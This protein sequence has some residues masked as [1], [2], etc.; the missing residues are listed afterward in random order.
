MSAEIRKRRLSLCAKLL[1]SLVLGVLT[2]E[3]GLRVIDRIA[4]RGTSFF[5][6]PE[7]L[8]QSQFEPHPYR[9]FA[10]RPGA[11]RARPADGR[12]Q[13]FH[14]NALGMRGPEV[15]VEKPPGTYRILCLGG[16]TTFGTSV[17]ED[18]LTYPA[19]LEHYLNE[20]APAGRTYQVWNCGVNGYNTVENLIYLELSLVELEPDAILVYDAANDARPIQAEGFRPDYSHLRRAWTQTRFSRGERFLLKWC[21]IYGWLTQGLER[22]GRVGT[23]HEALLVPGYRAL[24]RPSSEGVNQEGVRVFLRNVRSMVA[25]CREFGIEPVFQ[26]FAMCRTK[27]KDGEEHFLETVAAINAALREYSRE[28]GVP[29]LDVARVVDERCELFIDWMHLDDAGSDA[30]ARAVCEEARR[31]DLFRE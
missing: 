1:L 27:Q 30:H 31:L 3:L 17:T 6:P 23:L 10:Y 11:E 19:R 18:H 15:D 5:L 9:G 16:S 24:H 4:G 22:E 20:G 29:L 13:N 28:S 8:G 25:V 21:R 2:L 7:D 12:G 14:I 26:T